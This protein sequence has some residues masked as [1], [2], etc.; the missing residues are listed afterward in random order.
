MQ[1]VR[2]Q[3]TVVLPRWEPPWNIVEQ[4]LS[5]SNIHE[6]DF[7]EICLKQKPTSDTLKMC[8]ITHEGYANGSVSH[9]FCNTDIIVYFLNDFTCYG[10]VMITGGCPV[11]PHTAVFQISERQSNRWIRDV[12]V[13]FQTQDY[14]QASY[15]NNYIWRPLVRET[16]ITGAIM[17]TEAAHLCRYVLCFLYNGLWRLLLHY[18]ISFFFKQVYYCGIKVIYKHNNTI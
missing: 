8:T 9:L 18:W 2:S 6:N 3:Y 4:R 16:E 13:T 14:K 5:T 17:I 15:Q 11:D 10:T 7:R 1:S 12:Y